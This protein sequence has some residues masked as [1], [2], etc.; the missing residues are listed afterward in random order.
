MNDRISRRQLLM[1]GT[2]GMASLAGCQSLLKSKVSVIVQIHNVT[3]QTQEAYVEF[4]SD[5]E[6]PLGE[7]VFETIIDEVE[8]GNTVRYEVLLDP[9]TYAVGLTLDDVV[10]R[11]VETIEWEIA[12]DMSECDKNKDWTLISI[13]Q[14]VSIRQTN[15]NCVDAV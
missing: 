5:P 2:A 15:T 6:A 10:P 14:G 7:D 1:A 3:E 4:R 13:E 8:A 12:E 9:D 11:P